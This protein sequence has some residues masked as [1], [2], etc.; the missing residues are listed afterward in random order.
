MRKVGR[1]RTPPGA[2]TRHGLFRRVQ[3]VQDIGGT[4]SAEGAVLV[5]KLK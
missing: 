5:R 1:S 2:V 3:Q 4:D